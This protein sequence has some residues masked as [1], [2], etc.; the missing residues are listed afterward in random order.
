MQRLV[1]YFLLIVLKRR[2]GDIPI[3]KND[4]SLTD[5]QLVV[6]YLGYINK[7]DGSLG[8]EDKRLT[9]LQT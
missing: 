1:I 6:I 4:W 9:V 8:I 3:E 7:I 2:W 5:I